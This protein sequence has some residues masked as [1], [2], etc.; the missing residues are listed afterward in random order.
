MLFGIVTVVIDSITQIIPVSYSSNNSKAQFLLTQ[1]SQSSQLYETVIMAAS[2]PPRGVDPKS[3]LYRAIW[4]AT[5]SLKIDWPLPDGG[6]NDEPFRGRPRGA[7]QASHPGP[8]TKEPGPRSRFGR[9]YVR[10]A[11]NSL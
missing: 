3:P 1:P 10:P 7:E 9:S 5:E 11:V 6:R 8:F 4:D 2:G